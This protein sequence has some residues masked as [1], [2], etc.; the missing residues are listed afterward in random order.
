MA[1][2]RSALAR[3]FAAR[4]LDVDG[5]VC[6]VARRYVNVESIVRRVQNNSM[7]FFLRYEIVDSTFTRTMRNVPAGE[8][9]MN[10]SKFA[11]IYT[12]KRKKERKKADHTS[13][14]Q[15]NPN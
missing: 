2:R 13:R 3:S 12:F 9:R 1:C 6:V 5:G 8:K 7:I 10:E 15:D 14:G 11:C 4:R